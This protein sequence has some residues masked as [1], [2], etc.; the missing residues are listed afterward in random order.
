MWK[1][2]HCS[3]QLEASFA[4]CWKCGY[5][6][7]GKPPQLETSSNVE[8]VLPSGELLSN[9]ATAAAERRPY[10]QLSNAGALLKTRYATAY[11]I[12]RGYVAIGGFLK[13]SG[14]ALSALVLI[15][16]LA[17]QG[18]SIVILTSISLACIIGGLAVGLG[19]AISS[20]GQMLRAHLDT[21]VNTSPLLT[22]HEVAQIL[23]AS[24]GDV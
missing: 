2:K 9:L 15:A 1:C 14:V 10:E 12:A 8:A 11:T 20:L 5:D 4:Q 21:A 24:V 22:K 16:G 19:V 23:L 3:E 17:I 18:G 7:S 13:W 6:R